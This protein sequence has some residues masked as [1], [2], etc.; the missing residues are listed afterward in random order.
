MLEQ[1]RHELVIQVPRGP[2][3]HGDPARLAQVVANLL[4]NAAKYTEAGGKVTIEA[5]RDGGSAVLRVIDTGVGIDSAMLSRVFE[6]FAQERQTLARSQGGLG[7]GPAIVRSLVELHGG[8]VSAASGGAGTGSQFTILLPLHSDVVRPTTVESTPPPVEANRSGSGTRVLVVDD[9]QDAATLLGTLVT[10]F[11]Y[12]AR[13]AYDAPS[14]LTEAKRFRPQLA[15]IDIGLPVVDGFELAQQMVQHPLLKTTNLIAL[16]GYGQ[17]RDRQASAA[18]GFAA[19]LVK[20]VDAE[21]LRKVLR[22]LE[23][24]GSPA[25]DQ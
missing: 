21:E 2:T 7:L 10:A 17:E 19:H 1:E 16:T 6:L 20:P 13:V 15:L 25:V 11:G 14:A 4:T 22:S 18:A 5:D 23:P 8:T 24:T 9:N 3:I 12:D